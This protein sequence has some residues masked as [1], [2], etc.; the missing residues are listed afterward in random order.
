[1]KAT[2]GERMSIALPIA[3]NSDRPIMQKRATAIAQ[4]GPP[5]SAGTNTDKTTPTAL[6]ER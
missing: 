6:I 1:M 3:K 2:C 5:S 4:T